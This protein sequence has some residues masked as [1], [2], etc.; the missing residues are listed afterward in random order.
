MDR[1]EY[2]ALAAALA[3]VPDPR[4]RRGVRHA[5]DLLLVL[6]G[7][8]LLGG[9][10]HGRAI[11]Q[12]VTEH[13]ETL[14]TSL[15]PAGDRLPSESTL[16]RALARVD[17][18][19]LEARL[20]GFSAGLPAP[21]GGLIG[22]AIDGKQVRGAGA[23]GRQVH[24]VSLTR[25]ADGVALAQ[26]A[27]AAKS[28]EI[29]AAPQLLAGRDLAG[30]VTTVDALLAHPSLARQ[31]VDG[32]GRYLMV[33]KDNQ[34][35]TRAAI[36]ELFA[37]PPWLPR[38]RGREYWVYRGVEKGHGRL[39][40][41]TLEASTALNGYLAWPGVGQALRRHCRRVLLSTGEV[42]EETSYAVTS[43]TPAGASA[44]RVEGFWRGH[45]AIENRLH[46]PRDVTLGED[47]TQAHTGSTPH[48]LAAL[49][50]AVIALLRA[51]G[52]ASI[53]DAVRH[54]NA[55]P[56]HALQLL[57]ASPAGL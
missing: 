45:W 25:H 5:W 1:G 49:R 27:V 21:G 11:A 22:Q 15:R 48:A 6:I 32:G 20:S 44:A 46:Y 16:R 2:T 18:A 30:T 55:H 33:I 57:G 42:Q 53:A 31:I 40:T 4:D 36:A 37:E 14:R 54:F 38:E 35:E 7:A 23:H 12:W 9:Q 17:V 47:A 24:L 29:G 52:W 50:N 43:L 51:H 8:A 28:N 41:R 3:G 19:A 10:G 26:T 56:R 39:E 13:A 34:P